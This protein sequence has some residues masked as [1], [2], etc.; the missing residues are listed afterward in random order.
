MYFTIASTSSR[1]SGEKNRNYD[2]SPM[3]R[4]DVL[5][6]EA[7]YREERDETRIMKV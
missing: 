2:I 6:D 3:R 1:G 7:N 4:S 5:R